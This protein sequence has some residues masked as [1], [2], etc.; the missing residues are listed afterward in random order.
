MKV[1]PI[2]WAAVLVII[3]LAFC[4]Y[5]THQGDN[6]PIPQQPGPTRLQGA[7]YRA[8]WRRD[9][10]TNYLARVNNG[11][12]RGGLSPDEVPE[13]A[14][15]IANEYRSVIYPEVKGYVAANGSLPSTYKQIPRIKEYLSQQKSFG[16][17]IGVW[18]R[19]DGTMIS[20]AVYT[21]NP[22]DGPHDPWAMN[23]SFFHKPGKYGRRGFLIQGW[24]D[25]R[26]TFDPE[27]DRYFGTIH[28]SVGDIVG[29]APPG[30]AGIPATAIQTFKTTSSASK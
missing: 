1:R 12:Q 28:A 16:W 6:G 21:Q 27:E 29:S 9:R 10:D 15:Q 23:W 3:A 4:I 11:S 17:S 24:D 30:A 18:Y 13:E 5:R 20:R 8:A 26:V 19:L 25:G 2:T 14:R 22:P 7:Q